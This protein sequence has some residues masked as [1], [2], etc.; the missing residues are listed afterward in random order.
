MKANLT[1]R[2]L[3]SRQRILDSLFEEFSEEELMILISIE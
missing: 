2:S 1:N 3:E